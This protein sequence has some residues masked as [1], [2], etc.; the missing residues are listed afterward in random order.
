MNT[1]VIGDIHGAYKALVQVFERTPLE[2]GDT[3]IS[4]GDIADGW[5]E[6]YECV[7][8]LLK[9]KEDYNMIFIKGNHDDVFLDWMIKGVHPWYWLQGAKETAESYIRHAERPIEVYPHMGGYNI[10]LS[11]IDIPESHQKFFKEQ[12]LKYI[13]EDNN[14]FVH[15][16]FNRHMHIS[17]QVK[18]VL[19]WDRDLWYAALSF[20]Q[21]N[22]DSKFK[23]K[24]NF[25]DVFIG[26]TAT[27]NWKTDKPMNAANIWNL[28]TGA[29][30]SGK[31]TCMNVKTKEY[32]QSDLVQELYKNEKGRN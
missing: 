17:E 23:M 25:K 12:I 16:G 27:V 28:D 20:K 3:I 19:V 13:D 7:E 14:L 5:S 22:P 9:M 26:H 31:L 2:K 11:N 29:G 6:T 30:F 32:Y 8:L 1:Y 15:G 18:D 10:T 21:V 4:L 24:D